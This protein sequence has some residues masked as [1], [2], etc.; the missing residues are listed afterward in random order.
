MRVFFTS[1]QSFGEGKDAPDLY[2]RMDALL[3][4]RLADRDYGAGLDCWFLMF[5]FLR[6]EEP[7]E[8]GRERTL[9]KR[10]ANELDLRLFADHEAWRRARASGDDAERYRLLYDVA[11]R[12]FD[13][14]REKRIADFDVD[15]FERDVEEIAAEQGWARPGAPEPRPA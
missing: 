7:G 1:T 6:E 3:N 11:R 13:I 4:E 15:A 8:R 9:Y 5:V 14:M 10:K 12:S 2:M